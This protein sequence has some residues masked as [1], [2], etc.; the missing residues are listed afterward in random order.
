VFS[1]HKDSRICQ[2]SQHLSCS[3][4]QQ[5]PVTHDSPEDCPLLNQA[6][7]GV[8]GSMNLQACPDQSRFSEVQETA[9]AKKARK[10]PVGDF[11]C[12]VSGC[13]NHFY[14]KVGNANRHMREKHPVLLTLNTI[15]LYPPRPRTCGKRP[16][17]GRV[18]CLLFL[19]LEKTDLFTTK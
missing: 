15:Q 10:R 14:N 12:K 19:I 11:P 4:R 3:D 5:F 16:V 17:S 8:L 7:N 6:Q 9:S 13:P 2:S 18:C 1:L